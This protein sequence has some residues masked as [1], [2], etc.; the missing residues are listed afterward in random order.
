[1]PA[2]LSLIESSEIEGTLINLFYDSDAY[3][4]DVVQTYDVAE[5][6]FILI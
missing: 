6:E 4:T 2:F 1:V 3:L 5:V